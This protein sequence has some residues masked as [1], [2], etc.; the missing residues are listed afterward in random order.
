MSA[1]EI[2]LRF[3]ELINHHNADNLAEMMTRIMSL[4]IR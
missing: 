3:L 2:V 4:S 1:I